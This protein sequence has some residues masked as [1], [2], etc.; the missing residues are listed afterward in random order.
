VVIPNRIKNTSE[1][2]SEGHKVHNESFDS[3]ATEIVGI[4]VRQVGIKD[5]LTSTLR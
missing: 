4:N 1:A 2:G 3:V 5:F